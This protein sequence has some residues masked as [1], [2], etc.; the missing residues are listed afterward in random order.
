[1]ILSGKT[2]RIMFFDVETTGLLPSRSEDFIPVPSQLGTYP[3]I[4]QLS[5]IIFNLVTRTVDYHSD[6]YIRPHHDVVISQ[7]ISDKTGITRAICDSKGVEIV[8]ALRH[9]QSAYVSCDTIVSH[10][11]SFDQ[12]MIRV[13][14][15]RNNK[16]FDARSPEVLRMFN[17]IYDDIEGIGHFCTMKTSVDLCNIEVPRKNGHGTYKKWPTLAE[18]YNHLFSQTPTN[19]HNSIVDS[20]VGLR[21]YLKLRHD[22]EMTDC[23]F[24]RLTSNYLN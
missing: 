16:H 9:F 13:E 17:P 20:L 15:L 19:L 4:L 21:C 14:Q 3:H 5:F 12:A 11:L 23:E 6:V 7:F 22:Y 24:V 1:M 18:L 8:D 10:N 2:N